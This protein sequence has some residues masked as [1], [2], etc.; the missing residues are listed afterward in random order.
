MGTVSITT[1]TNAT[2]TYTQVVSIPY[3]Q[4]GA[5]TIFK[6][7]YSG[8]PANEWGVVFHAYQSF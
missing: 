4:Y 8:S 1:T 3:Y 7:D 5:G 2:T 6:V